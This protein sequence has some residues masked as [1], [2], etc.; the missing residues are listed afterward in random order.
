MN[1]GREIKFRIKSSSSIY[2]VTKAMGA[3]AAGRMRKSQEQ[4]L[5]ARP[6]IMRALEVLAL[7]R[8]YGFRLE[9]NSL[10]AHRPVKKIGVLLITPDR[11]LCGGLVSGIL[12]AASDFREQEEKQGK[13][14]SFIVIGKKGAAFLKRTNADIMAVFPDKS[15]WKML[16][17]SAIHKLVMSSFL[18]GE[19]DSVVVIYSNF[20]SAVKQKATVRPI[21]PLTSENLQLL[22]ESSRFDKILKETSPSLQYKIEP[23]AD[24]VAKDLIPHLIKMGIYYL[25]LETKASEYSARMLAMENARKNA[26]DLIKDLTLNFNKIRQAQ[27]TGQIAEIVGGAA[28]LEE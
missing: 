27:I 3:V 26:E 13:K 7:L 5:R 10:I 14:I 24:I 4:T 1:S 19:F 20:I 28:A 22:I 2:K 8:L 18:G 16:D 9:D 12:K 15:Y 17:A 21:L 25:M 23:K 6:Y 11:G